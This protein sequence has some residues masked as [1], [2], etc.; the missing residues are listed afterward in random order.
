MRTTAKQNR[1]SDK[2]K[3]NSFERRFQLRDEAGWRLELS[4]NSFHRSSD[5]LARVLKA[6]GTGLK[7][8]C[9]RLIKL[10]RFLL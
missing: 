6:M 8:L 10:L 5:A 3:P 4:W 2:G 7:N 1:R 9:L